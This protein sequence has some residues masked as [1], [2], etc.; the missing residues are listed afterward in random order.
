MSIDSITEKYNFNESDIDISSDFSQDEIE[1]SQ[2]EFRNSYLKSKDKVANETDPIIDKFDLFEDT[3]TDKKK[4]FEALNVDSSVD[5]KALI[6]Q[7]SDVESEEVDTSE[8][9]RGVDLKNED[10][11]SMSFDSV[12]DLKQVQY[13]LKYEFETDLMTGVSVIS[14]AAIDYEPNQ[15]QTT[16]ADIK[17]LTNAPIHHSP[18]SDPPSKGSE[19]AQVNDPSKESELKKHTINS[20]VTTES[21]LGQST[22]VEPIISLEKSK[23]N[24]GPTENDFEKHFENVEPTTTDKILPKQDSSMTSHPSVSNPYLAF[25]DLLEKQEPRTDGKENLLPITKGTELIQKTDNPNSSRLQIKA[26]PKSKKELLNRAN[27]K[28]SGRIHSPNMR[29]DPNSAQIPIKTS[30]S[31]IAGSVANEKMSQE[32]FSGY[33]SEVDK[34]ILDLKDANE[35]LAQSLLD[36]ESLRSVVSQKDQEILSFMKQM[37]LLETALTNEK[38]NKKRPSGPLLTLEESEKMQKEIC[39]QE[40]LIRGV[41]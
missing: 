32:E 3:E 4:F 2:A 20:V 40:Y 41:F 16:Q 6:K 10:E 27:S 22:A 33:Q 5:Y 14:E 39:D 12:T 13:D 9:L 17:H 11:Y 25:S 30:H 38:I 15:T 37:E 7:M 19:A 18:N 31:P 24:A 34:L 36:K 28:F 29:I 35:R 21:A 23:E 1:P 8:L 26:V